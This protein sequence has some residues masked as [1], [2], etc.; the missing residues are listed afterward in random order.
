MAYFPLTSIPLN[1]TWEGRDADAVREEVGEQLGTT[2]G[3][4]SWLVHVEAVECGGFRD[5]DDVWFDD[6]GNFWDLAVHY[7]YFTFQVTQA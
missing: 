4:G 2:L 6:P 5:A 1:R 7:E 3:T